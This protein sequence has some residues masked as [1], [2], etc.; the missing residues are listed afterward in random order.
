MNDNAQEQLS[1]EI[2]ATF[3]KGIWSDASNGANLVLRVC[4]V[5]RPSPNDRLSVTKMSKHRTIETEGDGLKSYAAICIALL[6]GRR[7]ICLID[8][9]ELCLHPPQAYSLGAF[10]GE[11]GAS[12]ETATYVATHSSQILR[13][14]IQSNSKVDIIRLTRRCGAFSARRIPSQQLVT[15]LKKPTLRAE[16]VLD[17]IFSDSVIIVEADS[18]R[19]VYQTTL[20]TLKGEISLSVHFST[21]G[22]AGGI[23]D[24][25]AFYRQLGIPVAVIADLDVITDDAVFKK[26]VHPL[27]DEDSSVSLVDLARKITCEIMKLTP[28]VQPEDYKRQLQNILTLGANWENGDDLKIKKCLRELSNRLDRG[29]KIKN[30]GINTLPEHIAKSLAELLDALK[31]IGLFLVP[32]GELE[33]WLAS[34]NI[35]ASKENKQAWANAAAFAIQSKGPS[36]TDIWDFMRGVSHN[37]RKILDDGNEV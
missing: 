33:D 25:C 30:G 15:A 3:G 36:P 6:L 37:L 22:G 19:L 17:G 13:G 4:D 10:I 1:S 16:S 28:A 12:E 5:Q 20:E 31:K 27:T 23:S 29:R 34:E 32:V 2:A 24:I 18:D 9:P 8:E 7:P 14:I 11:H 26:I 35:G 21:S